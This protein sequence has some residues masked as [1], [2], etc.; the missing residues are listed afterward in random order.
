MLRLINTNRFV[1]LS[2]LDIEG[3]MSKSGKATKERILDAAEALVFEHGFAATSLDSVL[4]RAE[5]TKGAF[6]YHFKNKAELGTALMRRFG[7]EDQKFLE[8]TMSRAEKLSAD[9][10]QQLLIFVG[11]MVEPFEDLT[12]PV[13]G[14]L[15][16]SYV[17]QRLEFSEDVSKI[18][19]D[20]ILVW[21]KR[22]V[23]KLKAI[24][25]LDPALDLEALADQLTVIVE[26]SYI[27]SRLLGDPSLLP[28]QV[29]HFK[30]Y[31]ELLLLEHDRKA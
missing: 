11:L 6:F 19:S 31:L 2:D 5:L 1:F 21:R 14:C 4:E 13:P 10:R 27:L 8:A 17:Y 30:R 9:P 15:F 22:I 28:R 25:D 24:D 18:A 3:P 29:K 16:A 26:G 12:E 23:E 7:A 20:T